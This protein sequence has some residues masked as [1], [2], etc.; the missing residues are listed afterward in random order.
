MSEMATVPEMPEVPGSRGLRG[1]RSTAAWVVAALVGS[2]VLGLLGGV[3][4]GEFAP[5]AMLQEIGSG[6]AQLINIETRAYFGADVWFCGIALAAGLLTGVL[7][8]LFG[9]A[10]R[11]GPARPLAATALILGALGGGLVM[12]W[13]G[14]QIGLSAS[15]EGG[16]AQLPATALRGMERDRANRFI[17]Q[18]H[19]RSVRENKIGGHVRIKDV[20]AATAGKPGVLCNAR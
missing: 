5:R 15:Q 17:R 1:R 11:T 8:Y 18:F 3:I 14:G 4:W 10:R 19:A 6:T 20:C 16:A 2:A 7:G 13:L 9:I 12:M